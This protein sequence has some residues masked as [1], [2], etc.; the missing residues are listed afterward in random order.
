M[1]ANANTPSATPPATPPTTPP[2][3][4]PAT[5]PATPPT[6]PPAIGAVID[7]AVKVGKDVVEVPKAAWETLLEKLDKLL[8]SGPTAPPLPA[9]KLEAP[10][11]PD[12]PPKK[13]SA[14]W[15]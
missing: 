7:S 13:K 4:P 5:P 12:A 11:T 2:T 8:P 6:T 1:S 3:T 15:G 9:P 14:W 10:T